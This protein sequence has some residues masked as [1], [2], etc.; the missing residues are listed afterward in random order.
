MMM[1]V[2]EAGVVIGAL[3]LIFIA[4]GRMIKDNRTTKTK[5]KNE[6]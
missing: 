6:N 5:K 4:L 3:A 1:R 2:L